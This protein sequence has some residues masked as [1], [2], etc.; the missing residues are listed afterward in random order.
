MKVLDIF[1]SD[2]DW[3]GAKAALLKFQ[4]ELIDCG[5]PD[6][7]VTIEQP[8]IMLL[9]D[10]VR[11]MGMNRDSLNRKYC[12]AISSASISHRQLLF[13]KWLH[14]PVPQYALYDPI[15]DIPASHEAAFR[16]LL[17]KAAKRS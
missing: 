16:A 9:N 14:S 17:E 4:Q 3:S 12:I 15:T 8:S 11:N 2:T 7:E 6:L 5:D 1:E 13:Y 10:A